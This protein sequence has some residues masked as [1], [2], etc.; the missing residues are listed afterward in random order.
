MQYRK[1]LLNITTE[2]ADFL[3]DMKVKGQ[4]ITDS[5]NIAIDMYRTT[6]ADQTTRRT[7]AARKQEQAAQLHV[8]E[9][10]ST[11]EFRSEV[12]KQAWV[13][14][15]LDRFDEYVDVI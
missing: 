4:L 6:I 7:E 11:I 8:D 5:I 1:M 15:V 13:A 14:A 3:N 10:F 9:L 12:F 2:N